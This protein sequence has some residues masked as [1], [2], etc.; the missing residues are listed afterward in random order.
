MEREDFV[1]KLGPTGVSLVR[2]ESG[3]SLAWDG[4]VVV[5]RESH[6]KPADT[7]EVGASSTNVHLGGESSKKLISNGH[8]IDKLKAWC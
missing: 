4:Q 6:S 2:L 5:A 3:N 7:S 8:K 1:E